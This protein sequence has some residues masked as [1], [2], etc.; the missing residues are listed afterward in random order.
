[1]WKLF[2]DGNIFRT[3]DKEGFDE[4]ASELTDLERE[5]WYREQSPKNIKRIVTRLARKQSIKG[6]FG[7]KRVESEGEGSEGGDPAFLDPTPEKKSHG[8][9]PR[10][11]ERA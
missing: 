6:M 5:I 8:F 11:H 4:F 1:M 9:D 2:S 3:M 7:R 10:R